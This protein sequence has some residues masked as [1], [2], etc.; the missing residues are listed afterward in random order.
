MGTLS[1]FIAYVNAPVAPS[2]A[3]LSH[4]EV[5]HAVTEARRTVQLAK[6]Q[7]AEL[8]TQVASEVSEPKKRE[9]DLFGRQR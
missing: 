9:M 4:L 3:L 1:E 6:R 5:T 7:K 8:A 2:A